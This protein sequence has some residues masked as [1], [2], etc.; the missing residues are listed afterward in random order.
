MGR[1]TR[2]TRSPYEKLEIA[3]G[4][5]E[6]ERKFFE[7]LFAADS[8]ALVVNRI[9]HLV[10]F[11]QGAESF[12]LPYLESHTTRLFPTQSMEVAATLYRL[13]CDITRSAR[14]AGYLCVKGIPEQALAVL[15]GAVEQIGVYTHV[16][17]DPGKYRFV[18]DSDKLHKTGN[19]LQSLPFRDQML[20][21][22]DTDK[23]VRALRR[24]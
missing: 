17:R 19:H 12:I 6:K 2:R 15:R 14:L 8:V 21:G 20:R 24:I 1:K 4:T 22:T 3:T 10:T 18:P 5:L 9:I 13:L 11:F 23:A 16:W 7:A